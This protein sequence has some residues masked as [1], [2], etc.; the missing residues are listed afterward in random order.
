MKHIR[1]LVLKKLEKKYENV[2]TNAIVMNGHENDLFS[3]SSSSNKVSKDER[4][5]FIPYVGGLE[6]NNMNSEESVRNEEP[7]VPVNIYVEHFIE[8]LKN[9][10]ESR[11]LLFDEQRQRKFR[12]KLRKIMEKNEKLESLQGLIEKMISILEDKQK[13]KL[14][15]KYQKIVRRFQNARNEM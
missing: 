15:K 9:L 3:Y 12:K 8:K 4:K 11:I 13:S 1:E 14:T 6:V 7:S 2:L 10:I 5:D